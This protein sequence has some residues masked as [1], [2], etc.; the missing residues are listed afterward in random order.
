MVKI[1]KPA[2]AQDVAKELLRIGAIKIQPNDPFTWTSGLISPM[3]CNNR[4]KLS[5]VDV[6]RFIAKGLA[7]NVRDK[8]PNAT[9]IAGVATGAIAIGLLVAE[10]LSLPFVYVRPKAKEH[11]LGNQIEGGDVAGENVVV[12]EDL[13]STGGSSLSAVQV[14]RDA[15]A[16]V[17]D[18]NAIVTYGFEKAENAFNE[19]NVNLYPLC[20]YATLVLTGISEGYINE[21]A[22]A[23][24]DEWR[25]SASAWA[26][27][28]AIDQKYLADLLEV[29]LKTSSIAYES[30]LYVATG[31]VGNLSVGA[32]GRM[33]LA[34]TGDRERVI[35]LAENA[36]QGGKVQGDAE[37]E[38]SSILGITKPYW[39]EIADMARRDG[40]SND[41]LEQLKAG[42]FGLV[43]AAA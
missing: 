2:L 42:T 24:L 40:H 23:V 35:R 17:L 28:H 26:W 29:N 13:I 14:L 41:V 5:H 43:A 25:E 33:I 1:L 3:Y 19:A 32:L 10:E 15:G 8:S 36:T 37:K 31:N 34:K 27:K 7:Q 20:D 16:N 22:V 18:M 9:V 30:S 21:E 4:G 39:Q 6:R 11:G 38:I 12:V